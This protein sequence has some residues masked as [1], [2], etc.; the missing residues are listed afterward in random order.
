MPTYK[1]TE[2]KLEEVLGQSYVDYYHTFK[3][4]RFRLALI[5]E[6]VML[7]MSMILITIVWLNRTYFGGLSWYWLLFPLFLLLFLLMMYFLLRDS[8]FIEFTSVMKRLLQ[9]PILLGL[10]IGRKTEKDSKKRALLFNPIKPKEEGEKEEDKKKKVVFGR[11][12]YPFGDE[13]F[14]SLTYLRKQGTDYGLTGSNWKNH[15][16]VRNYLEGLEKKGL[17]VI[18]GG[19]YKYTTWHFRFI[20]E[21]GQ[22]IDSMKKKEQLLN[23]AWEKMLDEVFEE[24]RV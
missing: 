24:R 20:D 9:D 8:F 11:Y 23:K 18:E 13:F 5:I 7:L 19:D 1:V 21:Y 6:G 17:I 14:K 10:N 22:F 15:D 16:S 2:K 4:K 12:S 3:S